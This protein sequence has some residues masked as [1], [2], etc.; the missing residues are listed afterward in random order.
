MFV[1]I[2]ASLLHL[3]V[4]PRNLSQAEKKVTVPKP[5]QI[6]KMAIE[7]WKVVV[8]LWIYLALQEAVISF[9][10]W[11]QSLWSNS[12]QQKTRGNVDQPPMLVLAEFYKG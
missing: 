5:E 3:A 8:I 9:L 1:Y 4:E 12:Q 7:W 6:H 11:N 10:A 2:C